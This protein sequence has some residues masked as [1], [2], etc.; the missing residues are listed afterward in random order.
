MTM[1]YDD[2]TIMYNAEDTPAPHNTTPLETT[3]PTHSIPELDSETTAAYSEYTNPQ[4]DLMQ[5][6]E[7]FQKLWK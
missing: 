4:R 7:H 3:P 2:Q 1:R 6:Q 5:L